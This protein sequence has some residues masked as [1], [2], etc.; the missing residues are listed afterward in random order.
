M[1]DVP[2]NI[3]LAHYRAIRKSRTNLRNKNTELRTEVKRLEEKLD[4]Q[5]NY[6]YSLKYQAQLRHQQS[7][8]PHFFN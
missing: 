5:A 2:A 8:R 1:A 4:V 7:Q 3:S 6:I